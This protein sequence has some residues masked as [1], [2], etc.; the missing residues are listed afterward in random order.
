[1]QDHAQTCRAD[2][3]SIDDEPAGS[4][5]RHQVRACDA[6]QLPPNAC[7][8]QGVIPLSLPA[9]WAVSSCLLHAAAGLGELPKLT[10]KMQKSACLKG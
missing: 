10:R 6:G 3:D 9:Q 7:S 4:A 5:N 2:K 1:M 8:A